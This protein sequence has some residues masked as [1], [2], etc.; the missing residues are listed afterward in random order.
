MKQKRKFPKAPTGPKSVFIW[1]DRNHV[2]GTDDDGPKV[3]TAQRFKTFKKMGLGGKLVRVQAN[4]KTEATRL[5]NAFRE[6]HDYAQ[7]QGLPAAE[8]LVALS[9]AQPDYA[10][11]LMG[12]L[13]LVKIVEE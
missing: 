5:Y 12:A 13:A 8:A 6:A 3:V 11:N 1:V 10:A 2:T 9:A 4:T 7:T